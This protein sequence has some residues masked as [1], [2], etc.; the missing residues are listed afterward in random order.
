[1]SNLSGIVKSIRK[2]MREDQGISG[3]GQRIEQLAWMLFLK[4]MDD[5]DQE[6]EVMSDN[7]VSPIPAKFQWR[8]WA[9]DDE[10][11]TGDELQRFIDAPDSLF[12][13]LKNLSVDNP[14][15]YM[16]REVF[17]GNNNYMKSGINL[18]KVVN[19][20]N[21]IDFNVATERHLFGEIYESILKELQSAGDYG[22]FYTPRA[23]T[24]FMTDM[25]DPKLGE[26]VLDP[27]CGTGGFLTGVAE[28]LKAQANSVEERNN[29]QQNVRGWEWKP[30]PY[31]LATTNLIL[32]DIEMPNITY[33][34]A[35]DK[36][37]SEYRH[38]E[39][40]DVILAN[41]PFGG[42]VANN[43]ENNFPQ[44]F[45]TKE[46][47]DLFLVMMIHLL[48]VHGRAAIVLFNG[49]LTG[50][51]VKQ[52]IREKW[53]TDCNLHT[54]IRLPNSV[55]SP[56]ATVATSIFFFD[57]APAS[58]SRSPAGKSLNGQADLFTNL[59]VATP[60]A[61][62]ATQTI[63]YYEHMLPE[64]QKNYSKTKPIRREDFE[65]IA[66]WWNNRQESERAWKVDIQT[67][68]DRGFDLDIDNPYQKEEK[69]DNSKLTLKKYK[70]SQDILRRLQEGLRDE[71]KDILGGISILSDYFIQLTQSPNH[72]EKLRGWIIDLG[73][74]GQLT[75]NWRSDHPEAEPASAL[76]KRIQAEKACLVKEKKIKKPKPLLPID[77]DKVP[78]ASP[79]GWVW[80][81]VGDFT[82]VIRGKSPKYSETGSK[83]ILNQK[84][85]RWFHIE[86][87][88]AKT[89]VDEWF[90][91]VAKSN[92]TKEGDVLVN[93]TGEGTIGRSALV[94][95]DSSGYLFDSHVLR[96]RQILPVNPYFVSL[97][98][99]AASGQTQVEEL[100]GAKSTKQTELGVN[101]LSA[102]KFPLPPLAEQQAIVEKVE[103]LLA[104]VGAL[105]QEVEQNRQHAEQLLQSVLREVM[106]GTSPSKEV[107]V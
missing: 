15:A 7:Y 25:V 1:M 95:N 104:K 29:I 19:K 106:E 52:R 58:V 73:V 24:Q 62:F 4:I 94:R 12:D 18:R 56:Y 51:G 88:H 92:Q 85:V 59:E 72:L 86:V 35:L 45:R 31:V 26:V 60:P 61:D 17:E 101:N 97:F 105:E 28:H 42:T 3:D 6:L 46:S 40:V 74:R 27:A 98:I 64:G 32:H 34:D 90:D 68:V 2:I 53:L 103:S 20:L 70:E 82:E 77:L 80:C 16:V 9:T 99:N 54:I 44:S 84:C 22:E 81:R 71:L 23:V 11:M 13:T 87:D 33:R 67:I 49:S 96:I 14:R 47:A 43:N 36:P 78:F 21:E 75:R 30:L 79:E 50:E 66:K 10:G 39:R 57:K 102:I 89:V 65:P 41:P 83:R 48:K 91:S 38:R 93:S 55:F 107:A 76:L 69:F 100:K 5:K 37:L 63:W 8:N